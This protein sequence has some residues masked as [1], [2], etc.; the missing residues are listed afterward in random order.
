M[1]RSITR[2]LR[3]LA[4][5]SAVLMLTA[6]VASMSQAA[7]LVVPAGATHIVGP[8]AA[9][10]KLERLVLEDDATIRFAPG[11]SRWR[12]D[13]ARV[14]IGARVIVDGRGAPGG[15]GT[16]G[17]AAP[18]TPAPACRDG[19]A[20]EPGAA[21]TG[22]GAGVALVM[23][24]GIERLGSVQVLTDG[25]AGG[26]GGD[27]GAGQ[28]GGPRSGPCPTPAGG[29][30]GMGG[31]G[32]AG[33]NAGSVEIAYY[34]TGGADG[35]ALRRGI[36]VSAEPGSAGRSGA[37]GEGGAA[38]AGSF[39]RTTS[40]IGTRTWLADGE[41]GADGAAGSAGL[42]GKSAQTLVQ[43]MLAVPGGAAVSAVRPAVQ[44]D[45]AEVAA[46]R[47]QLQALERRLQQLE[48]R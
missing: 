10:L 33:G 31:A 42:A 4:V 25:G 47:A 12:V 5:R 7:E 15:A 29:A 26:A 34:G 38:E 19:A 11:V 2:E 30:G 35:F 36:T 24:L 16:A 13:A 1:Q 28:P 46:L 32:G 27:G 43:E 41:P 3:P 39:S 23:R 17:A 48:A 6:A 18:A 22:G 21:G 40:P 20:G 14:A 8:E 37:G 9:E 45:T 44:Q